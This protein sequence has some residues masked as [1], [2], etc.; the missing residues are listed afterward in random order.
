MARTVIVGRRTYRVLRRGPQSLTL[1]PL[2]TEYPHSVLLRD[3][4]P[5]TRSKFGERWGMSQGHG[6][7]SKVAWYRKISDDVFE[8]V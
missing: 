4:D 1:Q 5:G 7:R 2:D 6:Q 3:P 8:T